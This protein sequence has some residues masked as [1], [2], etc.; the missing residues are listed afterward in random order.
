MKEK[1]K[2]VTPLL[3]VDAVVE[4]PNGIVLI[5]RKNPPFGWALPGGFVEVGETVENAVIRELFEETN[6]AISDPKLI[7]VY[8]DP[9]RDP[10]F[11]T[12]TVAFSAK[13]IQIPKAGDDAKEVRIFPKDNLPANIVFDHPTIISDFLQKSE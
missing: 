7:G 3:T 8:S 12:A 11:H 2:P 1:W 5:K 13:S 4:T 9:K 10:R 6:L